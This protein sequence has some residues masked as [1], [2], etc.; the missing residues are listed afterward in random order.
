MS[1]GFDINDFYLF[2][3]FLQD[4]KNQILT[5]N[6]WLRMVRTAEVLSVLDHVHEGSD[7]HSVSPSLLLSPLESTLCPCLCAFKSWF[8]HYLQ[9]NQSEHPGVKNLRFTTDQIWTPDILLYNR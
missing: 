7:L 8:D 2:F 4:E 5:T 3:D 6:I 1:C 9:W